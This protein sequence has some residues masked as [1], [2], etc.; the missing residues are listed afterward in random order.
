MFQLT[1]KNISMLRFITQ[2]ELEKLGKNKMSSLGGD[3]TDSD[4]LKRLIGTPLFAIELTGYL[5]EN[6]GCSW[7]GQIQVANPIEHIEKW[8][9]NPNSVNK[10]YI[11][12]RFVEGGG[13][14]GTEISKE[15]LVKCEEKHLESYLGFSKNDLFITSNKK[16]AKEIDYFI[17][18]DGVIV[19][20]SESK[21]YVINDDTLLIKRDDVLKSL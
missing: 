17:G 15:M 4:V 14:F 13:S 16:F 21:S 18:C 19:I 10:L 6:D 2:I 8:Y 5:H 7:D 1:L 12:T 20:M 11:Y 9:N 3:E